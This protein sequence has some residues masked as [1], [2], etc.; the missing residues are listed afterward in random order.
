MSETARYPLPLGGEHCTPITEHDGLSVGDRITFRDAGRPILLTGVIAEMYLEKHPS[1]LTWR[2]EGS[3][4]A[5]V[6]LLDGGRARCWFN[7]DR[8][9][10][11]Q[12]LDGALGASPEGA[13]F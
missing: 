3:V 4:F 8:P 5:E 13:L 9:T 1:T 10:P 7:R 6:D 2:P 11:A 12:D